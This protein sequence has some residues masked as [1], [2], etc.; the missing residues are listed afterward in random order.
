MTRVV[1]PLSLLSVSYFRILR[2]V[3]GGGC[4]AIRLSFHTPVMLRA[5]TL[6][7]SA[8]HLL[9]EEKERRPLFCALLCANVY[10]Y[11]GPPSKLE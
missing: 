4:N 2:R 5:A 8:S 9:P 1:G 11:Q 7:M 10:T 3:Q 6:I